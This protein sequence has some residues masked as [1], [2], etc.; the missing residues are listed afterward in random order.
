MRW[1]LLLAGALLLIVKIWPR[2][3]WGVVVVA[4]LL[5]AAVIYEEKRSQSVLD[6]IVMEVTYS[7]EQCPSGTPLRVT[8]NN[9]GTGE[10]EKLLFSIHARIPGYSSIVTPYT[11]RQYESEK[12]IAPGDNYSSCYPVPL[13]SRTPAA[14][15]PLESLEWSAEPD[16]AWFGK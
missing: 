11:Y 1:L 8:F 6:Q 9:N 3:L 13:L 14:E 4:V 15:L 2:A 10:L 16:R 7:P 5:T 12:I